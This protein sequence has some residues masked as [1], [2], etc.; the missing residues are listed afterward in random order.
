MQVF[1]I[2]AIAQ[3]FV[4]QVSHGLCIN[5][6]PDVSI[7]VQSLFS[8]VFPVSALCMW[9]RAFI[10]LATKI[11]LSLDTEQRSMCKTVNI[12]FNTTVSA[13]KHLQG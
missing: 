12:E 8:H 13:K 2:C 4:I 10:S 9:D 6:L 5:S 3:A 7:L 1:K 11:K